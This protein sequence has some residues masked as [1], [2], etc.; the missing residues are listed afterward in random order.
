MM[1][2]VEFGA[3]IVEKYTDPVSIHMISEKPK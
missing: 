2:P 3:K 1:K